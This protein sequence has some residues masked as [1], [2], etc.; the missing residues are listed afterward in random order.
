MVLG[1]GF[2]SYSGDFLD[3]KKYFSVVTLKRGVLES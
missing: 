3:S 2:Q 1:F